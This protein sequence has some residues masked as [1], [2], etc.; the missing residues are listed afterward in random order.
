[1]PKPDVNVTIRRQHRRSLM[2]RVVPGGVEVYIPH[3]MNPRSREVQAFIRKGLA[4]LEDQIPAVPAEQTTTEEI[5]AMVAEWTQRLGVSPGR[6]QLRDMRRKWGSCSSRG[7]ITL[8]TRLC[9]MPP[10]L[11]EYIVC[12]ELAHLVELNHSKAF[13]KL[14]ARHMP[15]YDRRKA[16]LRQREVHILTGG[17][18]DG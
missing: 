7:T 16:E 11:V 4:K 3:W 5:H 6:V 14:V 9:W 1:M 17:G 15:D 18:S 10:H 13:W 12:H 2:M 8:N